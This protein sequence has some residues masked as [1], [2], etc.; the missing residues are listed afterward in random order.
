MHNILWGPN[1]YPPSENH[2]VTQPPDKVLLLLWNKNIEIYRNIQTLAVK[3]LQECSSW[4]SRN[5]TAPFLQMFFLTPNRNMFAGKFIKWERFLAMLLE[6][7]MFD[8]IEVEVEVEV[9]K[10]NEVFWARLYCKMSDI[11]H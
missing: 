10:M 5:G 1:S 3:V 4:A 2:S 6:H 9:D 8:V 7:I 11:F